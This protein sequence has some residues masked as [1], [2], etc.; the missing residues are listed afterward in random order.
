MNL[1][2]KM[3][4]ITLLTSVRCVTE[5]TERQ[6]QDAKIFYADLAPVRG[7]RYIRRRSIVAVRAMLQRQQYLGNPLVARRCVSWC[8]NDL[9]LCSGIHAQ[10][11]VLSLPQSDG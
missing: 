1:P 11:F 7:V 8:R 4:S 10:K 3:A 2:R 5:M 9:E 6:C